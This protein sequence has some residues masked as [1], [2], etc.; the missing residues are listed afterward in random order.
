M[1]DRNDPMRDLPASD[2]DADLDVDAFADPGVEPPVGVGRIVAP[3]GEEQLD[4]T[5]E[6][7]GMDAGLDDG[8]FSA[9]EAAMHEERID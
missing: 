7:L 4:L 1:A 6:E 8:D 9:E 2:A 5:A 3:G